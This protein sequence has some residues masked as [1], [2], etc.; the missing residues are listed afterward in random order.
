M[1]QPF[2]LPDTIFSGVIYRIAAQHLCFQ[3]CI[4]KDAA[5]RATFSVL[6]RN[7]KVE[8]CFA[9]QGRGMF[10][11]WQDVKIFIAGGMSQTLEGIT[12]LWCVD[13]SLATL[14]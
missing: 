2:S 1:L 13:N 14:L 7:V 6:Y 9:A 5:R 12:P 8:G 11:I 4:S 10:K 3:G